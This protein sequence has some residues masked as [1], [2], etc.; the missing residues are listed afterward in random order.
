M[1]LKDENDELRLQYESLNVTYTWL[2]QHSFTYYTVGNAI[3]ISNIGINIRH[4]IFGDVIVN[5]TITNIGD[6]PMENVCVY[7][8][9]RNPD[10]TTDFS[11]YRYERIENLYIGESASFEIYA[12]YDEGQTVELFL[13]Y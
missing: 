11:P 10:G 3:N 1:K 13:V 5:G 8:I 7:L 2:K 9:L 12:E 6:K 4:P